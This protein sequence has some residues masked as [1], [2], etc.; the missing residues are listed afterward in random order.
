[1]VTASTPI[2]SF[3]SPLS[4]PRSLPAADAVGTVRAIGNS[5]DRRFLDLDA[6][7]A[8]ATVTLGNVT[9]E[10]ADGREERP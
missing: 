4:S 7:G 3:Q 10:R 5:V 9:V 8:W 1:M 6:P 2:T